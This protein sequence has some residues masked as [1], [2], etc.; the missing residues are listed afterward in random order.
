M[1]AAKFGLK[2]V[3][4]EDLLEFLKRIKPKKYHLQ[5]ASV[6][7]DALSFSLCM[8]PPCDSQKYEA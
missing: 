6:K 7:C 4:C 5:Y 1:P 3:N 2:F 8:V